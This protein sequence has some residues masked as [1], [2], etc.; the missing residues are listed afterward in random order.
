MTV[1]ADA[2]TA[3]GRRHHRRPLLI[4]L[5]IIILLLATA[6]RFHRIGA[7]S[8]WYDEGVAYAHSTRALPELISHL[9]T[10]VHVPA[11]FT[12]LGWW[13][14]VTGSSEFALRMLSAL[15]SVI[16]VAFAY[17]L[18]ARLFHP[19]AG[20]A[21]AALV[22]FN[23]FSIYYAQ[24]ARMYAMLTAIAASSMWL[25]LSIVRQRDAEA[26]GKTGWRRAIGLGLINALGL[27]T[28]F[29]QAFVI[30]TQAALVALGFCAA[31]I[32]WRRA[33]RQPV[34][35]WRRWLKVPL[36]HV[37]TLILFLP[38]LPVAI[39]QLGNRSHRLQHLPIDQMLVEMME[40]LAF[41]SAFDLS[42]SQLWLVA[43]VFLLLGLLPSA[44]RRRDRWIGLL[45]VAWALISIAVFLFLGLGEGFLRFL[46]P[47]QLAFALWLGGGV[48][49]LWRLSFR[50]GP[51]YLRALPKLASAL[52]LA[53]Y[54]LA[55]FLGLDALYHHPAFQRDDMRGLA[56]QIEDELRLGDAVIVS[57]P[58]LQELFRYYYQADA[59]VYP[60]PLGGD[61]E[62]TRNE[63]LDIIAAH[64]RMQVILYGAEQ[65]DPN[66]IVETTLNRNAFEVDDRWVDDL[67]HVLYVSP[68]DISEPTVLARDFAAEIQLHAVALGSTSLAPGDVLQVQLV[69]TALAAPDRRYKVFLQLLDSEG[70]LVA[71][72]DSEPVGGS[73]KTTSWQPGDSIVDNHGLL[74]PADLPAGEYRLIGGLYDINDP[75]ARLPAGESSYVELGAIELGG[76]R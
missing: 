73:S 4:P 32:G 45:P 43:C 1:V 44:H 14:S 65:Q 75:A 71:Q 12:L 15:F 70:A 51:S 72:R 50:R 53:V 54:L 38:W 27:Y 49:V 23:S 57:A 42:A 34:R 61:D 69:W 41:G 30:L 64:D 20:L 25:F 56:R 10:N 47:A 67:R 21:A 46:L 22:A 2:G 63:V 9:Q 19:V 60:L 55:L 17:G 28:H 58:G 76:V 59:P 74:I 37:L 52:A 31:F 7:Q 3:L 6:A 48:C 66:L 5:V 11:Y 29:A 35:F 16:G 36:A 26:S 68:A 39:A 24:E 18:G 40:L 8:L 33:R 13:R 62:A